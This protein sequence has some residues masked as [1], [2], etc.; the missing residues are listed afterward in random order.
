MTESFVDFYRR[1]DGMV[2]VSSW[3]NIDDPDEK[4]ERRIM[5]EAAFRAEFPEEVLP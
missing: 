1:E 2:V 3:R 5:T 4:P